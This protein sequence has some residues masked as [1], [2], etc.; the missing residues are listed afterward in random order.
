MISEDK[1]KYYCKD[2]IT[3]IENYEIAV[4]DDTQL[5]ICHHKL[6]IGEGYTNSK[7]DLILMNLYYHR[8]AGEFIFLTES[9]HRR[10]H[11]LNMSSSLRQHFS[12]KNKGKN[13]PRFGISPTQETKRKISD[14]HKGMKWKMIDGKRVWYKE[15]VC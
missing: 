4:N 8:P 3:E 13:N 5:W 11:N 15:D 12:E 1:V 9:E 10:L 2:D 6:G 14:A 7:K